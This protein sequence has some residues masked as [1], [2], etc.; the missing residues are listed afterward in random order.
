[1]ADVKPLL[2]PLCG[3]KIMAVAGTM[4]IKCEKNEYVDKQHFGCDFFMD[5]KPKVLKGQQITR[6]EIA[7]MLEGKEV[8]FKVGKGRIDT[9]KPNG[10]YF[11]VAFPENV[12]F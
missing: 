6:N 11:P 2:C 12:V 3:S 5:L 4:Y 1:M 8:Q 7:D 10:T 9:T